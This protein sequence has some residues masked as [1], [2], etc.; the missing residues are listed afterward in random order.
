MRIQEKK[1]SKLFLTRKILWDVNT[2][3]KLISLAYIFSTKLIIQMSS[4]PHLQS[5]RP[6]DTLT[7]FRNPDG[8]IL[9]RDH[10]KGE[11]NLTMDFVL[12]NVAPISALGVL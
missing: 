3:Q 8:I 6:N 9:N 11:T 4:F 7:L 5:K 2:L 12:K 10:V 1:M